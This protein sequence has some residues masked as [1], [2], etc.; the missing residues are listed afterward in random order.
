MDELRTGHL[1]YLRV[2]LQKPVSSTKPD[3]FSYSA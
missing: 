3:N 1:C 2:T